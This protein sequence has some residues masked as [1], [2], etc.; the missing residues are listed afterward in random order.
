MNDVKAADDDLWTCGGGGG[1]GG[2]WQLLLLWS[3]SC[4]TE[5][6]GKTVAHNS[7]PLGIGKA[8]AHTVAT[9][10]DEKLL[11]MANGARLSLSPR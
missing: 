5:D 2:E 1:G 9:D 7:S 10:A 11:Q 4:P 6:G 8:Q 3:Q